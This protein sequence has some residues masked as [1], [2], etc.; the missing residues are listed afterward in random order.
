MAALH[1][2]SKVRQLML[3]VTKISIVC[4]SLFPLCC[5]VLTWSLLQFTQRR[6]YIRRSST[7]LTMST[8]RQDITQGMWNEHELRANPV[9]R[10]HELCSLIYKPTSTR[11]CIEAYARNLPTVYSTHFFATSKAHSMKAKYS[12]QLGL[13]ITRGS[14][15]LPIHRLRHRL[16]MRRYL[17]A[18]IQ[19]DRSQIAR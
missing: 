15:C 7:C 18:C 14:D 12:V 6:R 2:V 16:K 19:S 11:L 1:A 13:K 17:Q 3:S 5:N 8:R 10:R 9:W 4:C